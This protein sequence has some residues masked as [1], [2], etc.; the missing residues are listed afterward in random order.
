MYIPIGLVLQSDSQDVLLGPMRP[1]ELKNRK[2]ITFFSH[3]NQSPY[4]KQCRKHSTYLLFYTPIL[5]TLI[6]LVLGGFY[7]QEVFTQASSLDQRSIYS[8]NS[9]AKGKT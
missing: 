6:F 1:S 3:Q 2:G 4:L 9:R 8:P 7:L 5:H